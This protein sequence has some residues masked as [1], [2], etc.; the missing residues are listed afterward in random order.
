MDCLRKLWS[1]L[2]E[3]SDL[4]I[5]NN[6]L[7]MDY[8]TLSALRTQLQKQVADAHPADTDTEST[9]KLTAAESA[10]VLTI[11][12]PSRILRLKRDAHGRISSRALFTYAHLFSRTRTAEV[13]LRRF[14]RNPHGDDA[15]RHW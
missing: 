1:L 9:S 10:K 11:L 8:E 14:N 13:A 6:D 4:S 5:E 12:A 2:Q 15:P 7:Y 3:V